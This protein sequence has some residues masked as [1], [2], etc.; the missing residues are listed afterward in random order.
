MYQQIG[1]QETLKLTKSLTVPGSW[2]LASGGLRLGTQKFCIME[3]KMREP[4]DHC[5]KMHLEPGLGGQ[6]SHNNKH[7]FLVIETSKLV[8][9]FW[10]IV[11]ATC[12]R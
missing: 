11:V 1:V 3:P 7:C 4:A 2:I 9:M 12:Y 10:L 6:N 5:Q 8:V